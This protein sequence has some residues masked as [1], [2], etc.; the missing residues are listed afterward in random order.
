MYWCLDLLGRME[1]G[2]WV[3]RKVGGLEDGHVRVDRW[4]AGFVAGWVSR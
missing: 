2:R 3:S 1:V 4:L